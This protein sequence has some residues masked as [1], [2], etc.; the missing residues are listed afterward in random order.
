MLKVARQAKQ[1]GVSTLMLMKVQ[2]TTACPGSWYA[3]LQLC[4]HINGSFPAADGTLEQWQALVAELR[5][6][7]LMWWWNAAY[8]SVQGPVWADAAADPGSKV[9]RWFS[10][11]VTQ[12]D[13]CWGYN[14]CRSADP[15]SGAGLD[16]AQGSWGSDN[17]L[18]GNKSALASFGSPEYADYLVDAMVNSWTKNLGIDG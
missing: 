12:Q 6:M 13:Q 3:G 17:Y 14:P 5:P 1:A 4:H 16:C 8:W 9:G 7:R 11:N 2:N 18:G 10:W 15:A